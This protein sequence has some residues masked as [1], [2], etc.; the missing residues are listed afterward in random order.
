MIYLCI[1]KDYSNEYLSSQDMGTPNQTMEN[2]NITIVSFSH[3]K[4]ITQEQLVMKALRA[5]TQE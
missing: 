1:K 4:H 5:N 3:N 2:W